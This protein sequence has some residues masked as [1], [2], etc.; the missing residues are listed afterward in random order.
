MLKSG[1]GGSAKSNSLP[2]RKATEK[3]NKSINLKIAPELSSLVVYTKSHTNKNISEL[4]RFDE[5]SSFGEKRSERLCNEQMTQ[6]I[7]YVYHH[8][9]ETNYS[10]IC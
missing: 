9:A 1:T 2:K 7:Q 10:L 8:F 5:I 4:G 3:S 6:Y